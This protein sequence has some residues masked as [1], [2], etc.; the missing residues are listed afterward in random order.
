[1]SIGSQNTTS[2]DNINGQKTRSVEEITIPV[3]WGHVS[4]RLWGSMDQQPIIALHGWQD[5]CGSFDNLV[6]LLSDEISILCLD[7]PGHGLSSHYPKSQYY[8]VYWDGIILLRRIVKHFKWNKIKLL[9]HSLGGIIAFLYASSFPNEVEFIIS[10]DIAGPNVRSVTKSAALTGAVVDKFL[11][12]ETHDNE[13]VPSYTYEDVLN[14]VE[15][16]YK[17][18]VTKESAMVLMKRGVRPSYDPDRYCFSRDTRLKI[19]GLGVPDG[20]DLA[21]AYAARIECAYLNIRASNG[22]KYDNPNAYHQIL[23]QIKVGSKRFEYHEVEGTHHVHL[24]NPERIAPIINK[25]LS[26]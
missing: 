25:F 14:I 26:T 13:N 12:Y 19:A 8:Y 18:S 15:D 5:N 11:I 9:G 10:I 7:M 23:D 17:G 21:L 16:A 22:L 24:N 6:P 2:I 4:G 1:M 20:I 3:P